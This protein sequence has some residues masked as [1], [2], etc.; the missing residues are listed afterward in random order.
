MYLF[1]GG[2]VSPNASPEAMQQNMQKWMNWMKDLTDKGRFIG[3]QPLQMS[4]TVIKGAE[5]TRTDGPFAEG[6][7]VVGG[8]L[9]VHADDMADAV[10]LS[11]EC[12]VYEHGGSV[13]VREIQKMDM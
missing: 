2:N 9:L 13:E 3:G 6:K 12:P 11:K 7:E 5:M 1:R 10:L 4:G 8:Y